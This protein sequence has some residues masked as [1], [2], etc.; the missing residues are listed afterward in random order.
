MNVNDP[1][2]TSKAKRKRENTLAF[3]QVKRLVEIMSQKVLV[4]GQT[5]AHFRH[6]WHT[7][8]P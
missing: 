2:C 3:A 7:Q 5:F 4:D 1:D 6:P 8:G